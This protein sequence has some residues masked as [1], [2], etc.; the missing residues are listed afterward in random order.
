MNGVIINE[1]RQRVEDALSAIGCTYYVTSPT[2]ARFYTTKWPGVELAVDY[3]D[4]E[5]D[6][7][8]FTV[9]RDEE[10]AQAYS[11]ALLDE[12]NGIDIAVETADEYYQRITT[13]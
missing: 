6:V 7:S 9:D 8:V 5:A 11:S 4:E 2:G 1:P 13:A 10:S 12:L 3:C